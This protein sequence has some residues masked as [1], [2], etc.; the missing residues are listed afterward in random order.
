MSFSKQPDSIDHS[1]SKDGVDTTALGSN[2]MESSRFS[3]KSNRSMLNE[4][5]FHD[6]TSTEKLFEL[7]DEEAFENEFTFAAP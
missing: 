6:E 7:D 4:A 2:I 3:G 5:R 1:R